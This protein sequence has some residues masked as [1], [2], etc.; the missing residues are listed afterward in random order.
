MG[1]IKGWWKAKNYKNTWINEDARVG[2]VR[3][4][5]ARTFFENEEGRL[6]WHIQ[7]IGSS[8]RA[9]SIG[10]AFDTKKEAERFAVRWMRAHPRG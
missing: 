3:I 5:R 9:K 2:Y 1:K 6:M 7:R 8:I 4:Y 10:G